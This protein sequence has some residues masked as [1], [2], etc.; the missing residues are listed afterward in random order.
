LTKGIVR[1]GRARARGTDASS[2]SVST[3]PIGNES[4][5]AERLVRRH[6]A[7]THA[8]HVFRCCAVER[9][10]HRKRCTVL[11]RN[12]QSRQFR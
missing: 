11:H 10:I 6:H 5:L 2:A 9:P 7:S 12:K 3:V 8:A 1:A 4:V